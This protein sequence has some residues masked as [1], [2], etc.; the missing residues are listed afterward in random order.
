MKYAVDR[1]LAGKRY[2]TADVG[3]SLLRVLNYWTMRDRFNSVHEDL[4]KMEITEIIPTEQGL[5]FIRY[6]SGLFWHSGH[7][8]LFQGFQEGVTATG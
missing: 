3:T 2:E 5:Q 8:V 7:V 6:Q 1:S 4:R